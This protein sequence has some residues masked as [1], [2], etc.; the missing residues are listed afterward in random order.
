MKTLLAIVFADAHVADRIWAH[1]PIQGDAFYS[2][3]QIL[4]LAQDHG[5]PWVIG[6]GDLLDSR[7]NR[8]RPIQFWSQMLDRFA[9]EAVRFGFLQGNHEYDDPPWL[10]HRHATHLHGR[11]LRLGDV[12]LYGLDYL[13][14]GRLQ[15]ALDEILVST[16][17]KEAVPTG[18]TNSLLGPA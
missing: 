3:E 10:S 11:T 1:R 15:E 4:H 18:G 6:C 16:D 5:C 7:T 8:S 14:A 17:L 9:R 12:R 13:P 2:V